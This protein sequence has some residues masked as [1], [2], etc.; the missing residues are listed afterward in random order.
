MVVT[1]LHPPP[2]NPRADCP[3]FPDLLPL[4]QCRKVH[5]FLRKGT[6]RA[7]A[8]ALL[9]CAA[10]L[11]AQSSL[12]APF[13]SLWKS[14]CKMMT[15]AETQLFLSLMVYGLALVATCVIGY[16]AWRKI[17]PHRHRY[18]YHQDRDGHPKGLWGWE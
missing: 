5:V 18:R 1:T 11:S 14:D 13:G 10:F 7:V 16:L 4:A 6:G 12:A 2:V 3:Y 17:R 9:V 8:V 15:P